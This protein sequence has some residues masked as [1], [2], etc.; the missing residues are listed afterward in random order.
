MQGR[1]SQDKSGSLILEGHVLKTGEEVQVIVGGN[2]HGAT[3]RNN[4]PWAELILD[5]GR[6][7]AGLGLTAW[8]PEDLPLGA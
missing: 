6:S 8:I 4:K 2:W 1:L 5:N 7:V 3:V